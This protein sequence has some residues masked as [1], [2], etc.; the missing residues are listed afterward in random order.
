M[1]ELIGHF[2]VLSADSAKHL[3]IMCQ[4]CTL[5]DGNVVV[6]ARK[7]FTLDTVD[8]E[9][10]QLTNDTRTFVRQNGALLRR[11]GHCQLND[12]SSL[13]EHARRRRRA[14]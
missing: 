13:I 2:E 6:S 3:V 9:E 8:G 1:T 12:A 14:H 11:L 4:E 7:V 5:D 10:V